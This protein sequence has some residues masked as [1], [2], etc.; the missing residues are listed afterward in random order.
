[1]ETTI[2]Y[3]AS[4]GVNIGIMENDMETTIVYWGYTKV[5]CGDMENLFILGLFCLQGCGPPRAQQAKRAGHG[6][7]CP[8]LRC[9]SR[10]LSDC[11]Q[12]CTPSSPEKQ[13]RSWRRSAAIR[14]GYPV[15]GRSEPSKNT[16]YP[17]FCRPV[18]SWRPY[19]PNIL[20]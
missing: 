18:R 10:R 13:C 8:Q 15:S 1:M 11:W 2:V 9:H 12:H 19:K 16:P 7:R 17:P 20:Y 3:L 5:I 4:V 6:H 14:R